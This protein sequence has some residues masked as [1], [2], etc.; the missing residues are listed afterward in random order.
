MVRENYIYNFGINPLVL[1][2]KDESD[3]SVRFSTFIHDGNVEQLADEITRA[4][5]DIERNG[6]SKIVIF[7]LMLL[8]SRL[9]RKPKTTILPGLEL[10]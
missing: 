7:D 8:L 4:A 5:Q 1:M 10:I 3:F 9:V 6:N 2:T